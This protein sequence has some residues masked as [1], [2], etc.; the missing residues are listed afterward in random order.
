MPRIFECQ[1][2]SYERPP[3]G[4]RFENPFAEIG[5]DSRASLRA[6]CDAIKDRPALSIITVFVREGQLQGRNCLIRGEW[7][8]LLIAADPSATDSNELAV[9]ASTP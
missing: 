3:S 5:A 8:S 2:A 7:Q 1:I 9:S 6:R 4:E